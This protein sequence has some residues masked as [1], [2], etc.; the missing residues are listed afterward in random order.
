MEHPER[1]AFAFLG[2][3]LSTVFVLQWWQAA[4]YPRWLWFSIVLSLPYALLMGRWRLPILAGLL[5]IALAFGS[6]A[7]ETHTRTGQSV[8][9]FAT[10]QTVT[11][12]GT[13]ADEPD[14]RA[15]ETRYT[16]AADSIT[17]ASGLTRTVEGNVLVTDE[18]GWP[19]LQY[20][21]MLEVRGTLMRPGRIEGFRYDHYLSRFGIY[22]VMDRAG[23]QYLSGGRGS[24]VFSLLYAIKERFELQ[25][26]RLF[27]EPHASFLMGLLTGSRRG[28]PETLQ[29]AFQTTGLTHLIAISGYNITI[30]LTILGALLFP[31]PRRIRFLMIAAGI[32]TFTLF[33]GAGAS[34]VRAAIMGI[35]GLLAVHA[36]RKPHARLLILWTAFFML[37]WNPK[38]L[39]Y[40]AGFQLSF[41][42]TIGLTE[43]S[44]LITRYMKW[45]PAAFGIRESLVMTLAAQIATAPLIL[46]VFGRLSLIAPLANIL[47]A[48][49]VPVAMLFGFLATVFSFASLPLGQ[50]FTLIGWLPLQ[51]IISVAQALERLPFASVGTAEGIIFLLLC[52]TVVA[53]IIITKRKSRS[54]PSI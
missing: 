42:A 46:F 8:D 13:I 37:I 51:W 20:G 6:V 22:A 21:D 47:A 34:V 40:D 9:T 39:W 27:H 18:S 50:I 28:I 25:I 5:G 49:A 41:L 38:Y 1:T 15:M 3:F 24:R 43:L 11:L 26:T 36:D 52:L 35:L 44:P 12:R 32:C 48:P 33:V 10:G 53:D 23:V 29:Q 30:I 16:L 14:R 17:F 4:I 31:L 7:R 2:S 54:L 19:Q 45:I